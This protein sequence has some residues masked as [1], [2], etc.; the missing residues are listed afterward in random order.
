MEFSM[1]YAVSSYGWI[2]LIMSGHWVFWQVYTTPYKQDHSHHETN[3]FTVESGSDFFKGQR[4]GR[5]V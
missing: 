2:I 3:A 4:L 5:V 1:D